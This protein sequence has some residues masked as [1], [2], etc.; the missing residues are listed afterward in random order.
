MDQ[1]LD[2]EE[3]KGISLYCSN[4]IRESIDVVATE[5]DQFKADQLGKF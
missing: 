3:T 5:R 4:Y 2:I 1:S